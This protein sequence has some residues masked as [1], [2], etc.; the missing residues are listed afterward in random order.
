MSIEASKAA[1]KADCTG[2][3]KLV[4]LAIADFASSKNG[5]TCSAS[6]ST[7]AE[8]TGSSDRHV[9]RIIVN[10][11]ELGLID[12]ERGHGRSNTH[13][14]SVLRLVK[15]DMVS[16][17]DETEKVTFETEKVTFETL[18]GDTMSPNPLLTK[19]PLEEGD[20][21]NIEILSKHFTSVAGI[22]P[23]RSNYESSWVE[24]LQLFLNNAGSVDKAKIQI[25]R[26]VEFAKNGSGIKYKVA[27][28]R[29]LATIIAN[30]PDEASK[31]VK[32]SAI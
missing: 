29:S 1:W 5:Y 32:V 27:S 6:I 17:I 30:M 18:K 13:I 23:G 15:G 24:P 14:Y 21:D 10:L 26:A 22:L 31:T 3:A 7:L 20:D 8:M 2:N 9:K 16:P 4:L 12:L 19:K 25:E 11:E 28:P